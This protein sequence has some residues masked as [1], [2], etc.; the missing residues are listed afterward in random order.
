MSSMIKVSEAAS[1]AIHACAWL[2]ADAGS[3]RRSRDI[4]AALGFSEAHF[5]KVM[6]TLARG[7]LIATT[8]GPSGGVRLARPPAK[9]TLLQ[10][11]E[12]IDGP[13][14]S[15]RCLMAPTVCPSRCCALGRQL[16]IQNRALR[17]LLAG[18]TLAALAA[19]LDKKLLT[20]GA[21]PS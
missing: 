17:Q 16:A 13:M 11:Y 3:S 14:L 1:I 19:T 9:V 20:Q 8:R 5:A 21:K 15:E 6:Q 4:C 10:I 12:L 7:G 18:T 2:A